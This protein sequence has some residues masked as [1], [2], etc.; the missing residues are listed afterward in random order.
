MGDRCFVFAGQERNAHAFGNGRLVRSHR[1]PPQSIGGKPVIR[2]TR[3]PVS[4][5]VN[6]VANAM[7]VDEIIREY[8]QLSKEDVRAALMFA[9]KLSEGD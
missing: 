6:F 7:T 9:E 5:I 8:P 2:G 1:K 4:L 3:I